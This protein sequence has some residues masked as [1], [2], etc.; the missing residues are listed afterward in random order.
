MQRVEGLEGLRGY[1]ALMVWLSHVTTMATLSFDK[2]SGWGWLLAN[3]DT[4]VGCFIIISGFVIS[5][6]L[7]RGGPGY[8]RYLVRRAMRLFPVYLVCLALSVV[9]LDMSIELLKT[10]PWQ[11]PRTADR[12]KYL[13]D[14]QAWFWPHLL[15]HSTLLHGVVPDSVLPSTSFAFMGQAW[16]L[17]L[18]WQFYLV[19]PL[20]FVLARRAT[21]TPTLAF[22]VMA[23]LLALTLVSRQ[24][25]FLPS[26]LYLFFIGYISYEL[27]TRLTAPGATR[28]QRTRV[29]KQVV[30]ILGGLLVMSLARW[31]VGMGPLVWTLVFSAL[32]LLRGPV[33]RVVSWVLTNRVAEFLGAV[34]YPFYCVHMVVLFALS[35]A[36]I[37]LFGVQ[38]REVFATLLIAGSLPICLVA[39]WLL[40]RFVETPM[41]EAGRHLVRRRSVTV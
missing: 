9:V 15:L 8:G 17:T 38:S 16:S 5:L 33:H 13:S 40:H 35:Y 26:F 14:S 10:M 21:W 24:S 34:S 3:G 39:S 36:L 22:F 2:H 20:L 18:E 31:K 1:M 27:H 37:H 28:E 23:A 11:G 41:I 12:L 30:L 4:A 32:F 29:V 6:T 7:D 25:S 19:A